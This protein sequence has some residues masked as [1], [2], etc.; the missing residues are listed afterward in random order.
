MP[1]PSW[2]SA[3]GPVHLI[4]G[5]R[6]WVHPHTSTSTPH[7]LTW[8]QTHPQ[9]PF[10]WERETDAYGVKQECECG[11]DARS[12][13]LTSQCVNPGVNPGPRRLLSRW[14][15]APMPVR[16]DTYPLG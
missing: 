10:V 12:R 9:A 8:A 5:R 3:M 11:P 7:T 1:S 14:P 15:A 16:G 6:P 2:L 13:V 4:R